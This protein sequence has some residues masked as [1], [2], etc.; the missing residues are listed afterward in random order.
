MAAR[1]RIRSAFDG[2]PDPLS[3]CGYGSRMSLKKKIKKEDKKAAKR[4]LVLKVLKA[5]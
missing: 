2:R 5:M 1:I 4:Q 3:E